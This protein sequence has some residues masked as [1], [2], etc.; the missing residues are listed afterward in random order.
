MFRCHLKEI[1]ALCV[2]KDG[3]L[4][5]SASADQT[6]KI[7]DVTNFDMINILK[8]D[9]APETAEFIYQPGNGKALLAVSDSNSPVIHIYD[10]RASEPKPLKTLNFHKKVVSLI[11]YND[12]LNCV[13]SADRGGFIEYWSANEEEDY[14]FPESRLKFKFKMDTDLFTYVKN[15]TVPLSM[16]VSAPGTRFAVLSSDRMVR[17][18]SVATGKVVRTYDE[19]LP[20]YQATQKDPNNPLRLDAIDFGRRFAA[21]RDLD[22]AVADGDLT[23]LGTLTFDASGHFLLYPTMI[24]VKVVNTYTNALARVL[25]R[26]ESNVRPQALGLYQGK[27]ARERGGAASD[28]KSNLLTG[29]AEGGAQGASETNDDPLVVATASKR[30]RV[31]IFS[32]R[33]PVDEPPRDVFNERPKAEATAAALAAAK[34]KSAL[35]RYATLHTTLGDVR[36]KLFPDECPKTVEN[37]ATHGRNNYYNNLIFHRV[38]RGFM[39]QTGDPKGDGTGGESIW[40]K[41]FEDEIVSNLRHDRPG[42]VSMANAGPNTNG[43]QFFITTVAVTRL[44]G[45]HT[46]FGRVE[47]GMDV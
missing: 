22:A 41:D 15:K 27:A 20:V 42:T 10:A 11:K 46:V 37:F 28:A 29:N 3:A 34:A 4:L 31:F 6:I 17:V 38:I 19:S 40:K 21:E 33:E 9:Y 39:V 5:C 13:I 16:A 23:A 32:R 43:S 45:K 24:G 47:R 1:T 7:Y 2:S 36:I 26:I 12:V 25:G 35:A 44:D 30:E 18:F 8:V 14:A